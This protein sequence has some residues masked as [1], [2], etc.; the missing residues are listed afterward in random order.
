MALVVQLLE[1][2]GRLQNYVADR[3]AY[4][5]H[6]TA[7]EKARR[8]SSPCHARLLNQSAP[9]RP[10]H[11]SPTPPRPALAPQD[12]D[13]NACAAKRAAVAVAEAEAALARADAELQ[14]SQQ[15]ADRRLVHEC[16]D[17]RFDAVE[18]LQAAQAAALTAK[19]TPADTQALA[20]LREIAEEMLRE[21]RLALRTTEIVISFHPQ[22]ADWDQWPP[23]RYRALKAAIDE[24]SA[25]ETPKIAPPV[26]Y[27][28]LCAC[29][30]PA[31]ESRQR[32]GPAARQPRSFRLP[33]RR[34]RRSAVSEETLGRPLFPN[35]NLN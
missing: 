10:R 19:N 9:S 32:P 30:I 26:D 2:A 3:E 13:N 31:S 34:P 17:R 33:L 15:T 35:L 27:V 24:I 29:L 25:E 21:A 6:R 11:A 28:S 20:F 7:L 4:L 16:V 1:L 5:E 14:S 8:P 22:Y 12:G 23:E 18:A